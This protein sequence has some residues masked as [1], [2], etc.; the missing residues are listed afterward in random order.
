MN[1]GEKRGSQPG[2]ATDRPPR[3]RASRRPTERPRLSLGRSIGR[4][5]ESH[6]VP[7]D[8]GSLRERLDAFAHQ[9]RIE[10]RQL[11]PIG[12]TMLGSAAGWKRGTKALVWRLTRFSTMRYDRLLADLAE[13]SGELAQR[14]QRDRGG[15]RSTSRGAPSA[16]G[17]IAREGRRPPPAD[18]LQPRRCG[19]PRGV[20]RA[21]APRVRPRGRASVDRGQVVPGDR[22]RASDGGVAQLRYLRVQRFEGRCGHRIEVPRVPGAARTQDRVAD[23]PASFRVRALGSPRLR[24]PLEAGGRPHGPE[25]GRG[26]PTG[27]GSARRSG[28]S[29]TRRTSR[30]VSGTPFV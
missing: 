15:G 29:R 18:G 19:A 28:S 12:E 22:A 10:Q 27:S 16:A 17:V 25:A 9:L 24:R 5:M 30:A 21:G 4:G 3:G 26:T 6:G 23:P 11:V 14:L 20:A 8:V 13:M 2:T 7:T 1:E